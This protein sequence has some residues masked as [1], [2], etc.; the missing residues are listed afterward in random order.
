[1]EQKQQDGGGAGQQQQ[2]HQQQQQQQEQQQQQQKPQQQHRLQQQRPVFRVELPRE[3]LFKPLLPAAV[4]DA[5]GA[6]AET[7][8]ISLQEAAV[9]AVEA[10]IHPTSVAAAA[11][12]P[13]AAAGEEWQ[14]TDKQDETHEDSTLLLAARLSALFRFFASKETD[15]LAVQTLGSCLPS[16]LRSVSSVLP[17]LFKGANG[18]KRLKLSVAAAANAAAAATNPSAAAA[19]AGA[20]PSHVVYGQYAFDFSREFGACLSGVSTA[21]PSTSE[22][23]LPLPAVAGITFPVLAFPKTRNA[24]PDAAAAAASAAA[25]PD[26][27]ASRA[28]AAAAAAA[29]AAAAGVASLAYEEVGEGAV[30]TLVGPGLRLAVLEC[31][32]CL[33]RQAS[34]REAYMWLV[35]GLTSA[36]VSVHLKGV[37]LPGLIAA[38]A[39]VKRKR[40]RFTT[41]LCSLLLN[42]T[43]PIKNPKAGTRGL[44]KMLPAAAQRVLNMQTKQRASEHNQPHQNHQHQQQQQQQ[45]LIRGSFPVLGAGEDMS[46][47]LRLLLLAHA[48]RA[49]AAALD[50]PRGP[51][52]TEKETEKEA[53]SNESETAKD[54]DKQHD[55]PLVA[56][57]TLQSVIYKA[58]ELS[59]PFLPDP[60]MASA[61]A[62]ALYQQQ[63]QHPVQQQH[64]EL[65]QQLVLRRDWHQQCLRLMSL[66]QRSCKC[67]CAAVQR[68][69]RNPLSSPGPITSSR[70]IQHEQQQQQQQLQQHQQQHQQQQQ[71]WASDDL[72]L[73]AAVDALSIQ[74]SLLMTRGEET[75]ISSLQRL[76]VCAA[77]PPKQGDMEVGPMGCACQVYAQLILQLGGPCPVPSPICTSHRSIWALKAAC[78]FMQH[79][80]AAAAAAAGAGVARQQQQQ[81]QQ[82]QAH[83][84]AATEDAGIWDEARWLLQ[85]KAEQLLVFGVSLLPVVLQQQPQLFHTAHS[86]PAHPALLLLQLLPQMAS[87]STSCCRAFLLLSGAGVLLNSQDE[88]FISAFGLMNSAAKSASENPNENVS[89]LRGGDLT[90]LYRCV[91]LM[92]AVF[93][94]RAQ[95]FLFQSL[96][97][98]K[99][100]P[101]PDA[102][103][104]AVL[105]LL[106][107][108]WVREVTEQYER[109]QQQQ[110]GRLTGGM[111]VPAADAAA[112]DAECTDD[113][114]FGVLAFVVTSQLINRHEPIAEGSERLSC[115]LNW[116]KLVLSARSSG[117]DSSTNGYSSNHSS[118][119]GYSSNHSSS[120]SEGDV[121]PFHRMGLLLLQRHS[122]S[123]LGALDRLASQ[124]DA[125]ELLTQ[126]PQQQAPFLLGGK[127]PTTAD[128]IELVKP[129]IGSGKMNAAVE[130]RLRLELIGMLLKEVRSLMQKA[131]PALASLKSRLPSS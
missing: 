6:P 128:K 90:L 130:Q 92:T 119:N 94:W 125:E 21:P 25:A 102:A 49:L 9:K 24:A 101:L 58:L 7:P 66:P 65:Q 12:A 32:G 56:L 39:K 61:A 107:Q 8:E 36:E 131:M 70:E 73:W 86:Y 85:R 1:M 40:D 63:Q 87:G 23:P 81:Q 112:A 16:L 10:W 68:V 51:E 95:T 52:E 123:L 43:L 45:Q 48:A 98:P 20:P 60:Y 74:C 83:L 117:N 42:K 22:G 113:L 59:V 93:S 71:H 104:S 72:F 114:N 54:N 106:K 18:S 91:C 127:A 13:A 96:L 34:G 29:D 35:E 118:S 80:D 31:I 27:P 19:S 89:F 79:A 76:N 55:E 30:V 122:Q 4:Q 84:E 111:E 2:L 105:M 124:M 44:A 38:A 46:L 57:H 100:H 75:V 5:L 109:Q 77:P 11:A 129:C 64:G 33:V 26:Q 115:V 15:P 103:C 62:S 82:Q 67:L 121:G 14:A 108:R 88:C 37:L 17:S 110:Q 69:L 97:S 41:Q 116:L 53:E 126:Q 78:I 47:P 50:Q 120:S 28:A 3:L 99:E